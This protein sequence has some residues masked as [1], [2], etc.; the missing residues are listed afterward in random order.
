MKR[1][2]FA[3]MLV[4]VL[5]S[6]CSRPDNEQPNK[7]ER[8]L[9]DPPITLVIDIV[10]EK[11]ESMLSPETE[12]NWTGKELW[13]LPDYLDYPFQWTVGEEYD[14]YQRQY[15]HPNQNLTVEVY[16]GR[17]YC[18]FGKIY[19]GGDYNFGW[20]LPTGYEEC[21]VRIVETEAEKQ[22]DGKE[23]RIGHVYY[24]GKEVGPNFTIVIHSQPEAE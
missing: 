14:E 16:D 11:G 3:I 23:R 17:P 24:E 5:F 22:P 13:L 18:V 8:P 1:F 2:Q 21:K 9:I 7:R 4:V 19:I 6:A 20:P 15:L 10:N 12:G